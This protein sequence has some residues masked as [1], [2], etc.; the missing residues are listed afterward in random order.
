MMVIFKDYNDEMK[1][2]VKIL[3]LLRP[4]EI[5]ILPTEDLELFKKNSFIKELSR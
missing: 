2:A 3:L 4:K 5:E 1:N